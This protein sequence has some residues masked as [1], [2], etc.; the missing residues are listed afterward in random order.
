VLGLLLLLGVGLADLMF[1]SIR[2]GVGF[3]IWVLAIAAA[4]HL[5]L[6]QDVDR[7]RGLRGWGVLLVM[8]IPAVD[9]F[10]LISFAI[11]L[12]GLL[13][14]AALMVLGR[15]DMAVLLRAM[16][17]LPLAGII[18]IVMDVMRLRVATPS[19]GAAKTVLFDWAMPLAVGGVF[20]AL[21]AAA[22][23]LMD[24]WLLQ[25]S[26]LEHGF[27]IDG[28]RVIF[29]AVMAA[30]LWPLLRLTR[31]AQTL[32]RAPVV[33]GA[34]WRSGLLNDRSVLRAL[35]LFNLIFAVQTVMDLGFLWGGVSL[36]EG[37]SYAEYAH[38]GAYP[39]LVT[40]LLAGVFALM[41]QP[42]LEAHPALR[43]LLYLW[44]GQNVLLVISSILRLDLYVD[45]Y[46]LTRLRFAA[47]VW[48]ALVGLGLILMIMQMVQRAPVGWFMLRA[49]GLG[50]LA[51]YVC[52]L[53]NVDGLIARTNL[54]Q[55]D[56]DIWYLCQLGEGAAPALIASEQTCYSF[57][58]SVSTPQDW[59][60]WG[61]RNARL[62]RSLAAT[63][64]VQ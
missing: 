59:R 58:P 55:P 30:C 53:V 46:D 3:V 18:L 42:F 48:M 32:G 41:S 62:R 63:E 9:L 39:L 2:P 33:R 8:L 4:I 7:K 10:Q 64:V 60:E 28:G 24:R 19:K 57:Q 6:W 15:W 56:P 17:R 51:I 35:V 52:A 37:M 22:N 47:F 16:R 49:A 54:A 12:L 1:W 36:P 34:R 31:L 21:I 26:Q 40:A 29:W 14:F 5:T 45:V 23:P 50:F 38:R 44:I 61:Y 43:G 11:A 27:S 25:L 13:F 20:I